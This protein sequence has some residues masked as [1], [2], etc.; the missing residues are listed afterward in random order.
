MHGFALNCNPDLSEFDRIIPCGLDDA[1][2]TSLTAE[3]GREV[4]IG[5]V[6]DDAVRCLE[7]ALADVRW[8]SP[9]VKEPA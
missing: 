6:K 2:A 8:K 4:T 9:T 5:E 7:D 1:D 3:L